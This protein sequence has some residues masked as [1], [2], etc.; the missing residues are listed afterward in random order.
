MNQAFV[1]LLQNTHL[2]KLRGMVFE[3][4]WLNITVSENVNNKTVGVVRKVSKSQQLHVCTEHGVS[5]M[6]GQSHA[7]ANQKGVLSLRLT[8]VRVTFRDT[9]QDTL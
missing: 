4:L 2:S 1:S 7:E 5:C 8:R 9:F 6:S 3:I